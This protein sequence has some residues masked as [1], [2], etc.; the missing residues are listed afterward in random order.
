MS[1]PDAKQFARENGIAV[2]AVLTVVGYA[3]V[4]GT[5]AG[6]FPYPDLSFGHG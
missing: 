1:V 4:I 2:A 3:A 5:F 6:V